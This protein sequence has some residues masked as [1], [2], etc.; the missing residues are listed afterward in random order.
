M[1]DHYAVAS[2]HVCVTSESTSEEIRL[3]RR[4]QKTGSD[5]ADVTCC[6]KSFQTRRATANGKAQSPMIARNVYGGRPATDKQ[7]R[8]QGS[9]VWA[10]FRFPSWLPLP[11][12]SL[13]FTLLSSPFLP[14]RSSISSLPATP[15]LARGP[16]SA[17][18]SPAR[19]R[20]PVAGAFLVS[21]ELKNRVC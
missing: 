20:V 10:Q 7:W 15:N 12:P 3:A 8:S 18:S 5:G 16:G 4:R 1:S 6:D 2:H 11:S 17:V 14:S 9:K 19:S 21:F 13:P